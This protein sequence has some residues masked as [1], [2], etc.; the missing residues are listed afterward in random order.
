MKRFLKIALPI[1]IVLIIGYFGY[2]EVYHY[3]ASKVVNKISHSVTPME[4]A[5]LTDSPTLLKEAASNSLKLDPHTLSL[6]DKEKVVQIVTK[7]FSMSQI[8][9]IALKIKQGNLTE[10]EK[11]QMVDQYKSKFSSQDKA[12]LKAIAEKMVAQK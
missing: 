7:D 11:K 5:K 3:V 6:K 1:I 2:R 12:Q 8:K 9:D 4:I 10:A